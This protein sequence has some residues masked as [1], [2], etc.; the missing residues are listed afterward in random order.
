[1]TVWSEIKQKKYEPAN[2][3]YPPDPTEYE[4]AH[5]HVL[6][7]LDKANTAYPKDTTWVAAQQAPKDGRWLKREAMAAFSD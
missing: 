5:L 1:M 6:A 3:R 2:G 4:A 7:A